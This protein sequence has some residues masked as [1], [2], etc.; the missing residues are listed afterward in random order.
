MK[1]GLCLVSGIYPPDAGGPAKFTYE[2]EHFARKRC[3]HI[4][5][6][7]TTNSISSIS[8][9]K[10]G[11][12]VRISRKSNVIFR[13]I[14]F[15]LNLRKLKA[16]NR[17][18]LVTG[19]F[20]EFYFARIC[21][22]SYVV[23]KLP[24]DIVWERARNQGY[25]K[26]SIEEFQFSKLP[27]KFGL[28]RKAFTSAISKA[29]KVIVPSD[30]LR[31]LTKIWGIDQTKVF[32]VYNS[33]DPNTFN[34]PRDSE[35]QF[36]VL[37]VC[38]LT[39]WKGV[40]ELIRST[41]SL[42]LTLAVVG[43]GPERANLTKLALQLNARVQFFGDVDFDTVKQL[44]AKSKRFVLNSAYEGLPHVLLEARA[45]NLLCL[46]REGTGSS[47]VVHHMKD[48]LL[49]GPSSG[50]QLTEALSFSFSEQ[51]DEMLLTSRARE[52]LMARF[53]QVD[54]FQ[55]ILELCD[56]F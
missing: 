1:T 11:S 23:F 52:D 43:D 46:A 24:G 21:R 2:F 56:G 10:N 28:M 37:T 12:I 29:D 41:Q 15:I 26:L 3:P 32:L 49:F 25:T 18:F 16:K 55:K 13:Y 34:L 42:G 31:E 33:V 9:L 50:M 4:D 39:K 27:F 53:N 6:I 35:K 44:Y 7:A 19:A 36:D 47:E 17:T 22:N 54:N 14:L 51:I 38:R 5:V 8:N 48:G 30:G 40:E 20:L 45:S